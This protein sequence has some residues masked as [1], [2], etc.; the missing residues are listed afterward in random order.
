LV[1]KIYNHINAII[2][3]AQQGRP[4]ALHNGLAVYY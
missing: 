4:K 2:A 3:D 1:Y